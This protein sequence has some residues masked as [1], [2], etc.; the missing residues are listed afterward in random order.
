MAIELEIKFPV[1]A[2]E[3]VRER[4]RSLGASCAGLWFECNRLFDTPDGRLRTS[5]CGLRLRS[6]RRIDA[7]EDRAPRWHLTFKGPR[8]AAGTSDGTKRRTEF[9]APVDDPD[10]LAGLLVRLGLRETIT[11]EKRRECWRLGAAE[12]VLD[13]LPRLGCFVEI[14]GDSPALRQAADALGLPRDQALA[15]TYVELVVE[16]GT[17]RPDGR[18]ELRF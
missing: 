8:Q 13:E 3:P 2:H 4:L 5:D 14:E 18:L 17:L 6:A 12:V 16:H 1:A 9:E 15:A 7:T 11:Y 10:E